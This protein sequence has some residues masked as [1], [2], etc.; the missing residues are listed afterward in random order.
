MPVLALSVRFEEH[1]RTFTNV[2]KPPLFISEFLTMLN[3]FLKDASFGP[4][5]NL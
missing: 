5:S 4:L 2:A 1:P 3:V